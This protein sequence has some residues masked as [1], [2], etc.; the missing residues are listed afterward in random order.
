MGEWS[1]FQED[2]LAASW[3]NAGPE[4]N[5]QKQDSQNLA[6]HMEG[7]SPSPVRPD[8]TAIQ[9]TKCGRLGPGC[10]HDQARSSRNNLPGPL[11]ESRETRRFGDVHKGPLVQRATSNGLAKGLGDGAQALHAR[12]QECHPQPAPSTTGYAPKEN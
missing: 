10:P 2:W 8:T 5:A 12:S 1:V 3:E 9:F 11:A 7:R 6:G 4:P